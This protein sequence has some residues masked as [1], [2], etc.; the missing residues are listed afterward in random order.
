MW[1][2]INFISI[3]AFFVVMIAIEVVRSVVHRYR[4]KRY[5]I[6]RTQDIAMWGTLLACLLLVLGAVSGVLCWF[7][8]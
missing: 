4:K 1:R 3:V 6:G 5:G 2:T 8:A 7:G